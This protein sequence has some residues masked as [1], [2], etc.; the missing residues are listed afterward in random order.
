MKKHYF[1]L[2]LILLNVGC[3][4]LPAGDAIITGKIYFDGKPA[5]N[6]SIVLVFEHGKRTGKVFTDEEG[7]YAIK[8]PQGKYN[9]VSIETDQGGLVKEPLK[10][11][12]IHDNAF[13]LL[14]DI[15]IPEG[16]SNVA[17]IFISK[18]I[19]TQKPKNNENVNSEKYIFSWNSYE[20]AKY[21][22]IKIFLN[23]DICY[24]ENYIKGTNVTIVLANF[25]K[26]LAN[27]QNYIWFIEAYGDSDYIVSRS[28]SQSFYLDI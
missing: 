21:Y 15:N 27:K 16:Q 7:L 2:F 14:R 28:M 10:Y 19:V 24:E 20:Y 4:V 1:I 13:K 3:G 5:K 18:T 6:V 23:D 11:T 26:T 9:L 22:C 17:P 12:T 8:I 25:K